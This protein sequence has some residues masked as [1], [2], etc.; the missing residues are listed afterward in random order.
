MLEQLLRVS[1]RD[2][3]LGFMMEP[4]GLVPEGPLL[5]HLKTSGINCVYRIPSKEEFDLMVTHLHAA[6]YYSRSDL[7]WAMFLTLEWAIISP[8]PA[9][10]VGDLGFGPVCG[11]L[12]GPGLHGYPG[13]VFVRGPEEYGL[14]PGF[15]SIDTV[16]PPDYRRA[17]VPFLGVT[18]PLYAMGIFELY[19]G[20]F[21]SLLAWVCFAA[22][23]F[24]GASMLDLGCQWVDRT[25]KP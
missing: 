16:P 8:S 24:L 13:Y 21:G 10:M 3:L 1:Y 22:G 2:F 19:F 25:H 14:D 15:T 17:L 9:E 12:G 5:D 7:V 23:S 6:G 18:V 4:S 11:D 20:G